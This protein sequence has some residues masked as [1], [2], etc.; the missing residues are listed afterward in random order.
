M[1]AR[2]YASVLKALTMGLFGFGVLVA[3]VYYFSVGSIPEAKTMTALGF[4]ALFVNVLV[5]VLLFKFREGG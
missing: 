2:T 5:A 3:A 4:L 1:R